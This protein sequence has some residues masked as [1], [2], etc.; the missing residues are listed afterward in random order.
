MTGRFSEHHAFLARVHLDLIDQHSAAIGEITT[1]IEDTIAPFHGFRD[2]ICTIPGVSTLTA[3]IIIAET[4]ADMTRFPTPITSPSGPEPP[5]ET[6][7][8]PA[9]SS[10]AEPAPATPTSK[11]RSAPPPWHAPK[12]PALRRSRRRLLQPTPTPTGQKACRPPTR[13][14]GLP[15]HPDPRQLITDAGEIFASETILGIHV[16]SDI[17]R[18]FSRLPRQHPQRD[19]PPLVSFVMHPSGWRELK[20]PGM[21]YV[22]TCGAVAAPPPERNCHEANA[23]FSDPSVGDTPGGSWTGRRAADRGGL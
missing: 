20:L 3:D 7:N 17:G 12:I 1:R 21:P 2:L 10:P 23:A 5:R 16:A 22:A 13:S 14:H 9:K 18:P 6:T 19:Q 8:P 15:G 11:V 4:G